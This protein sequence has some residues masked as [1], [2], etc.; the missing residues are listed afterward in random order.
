M[1]A[2]GNTLVVNPHPSGKRVAVEGVRRFNKAI[3]DDLGIDNLICVIA[4][5]TLE[6]ADTIFHHRD[7]AIDLCDRWASRRSCGAQQ[8]QKGCGCRSG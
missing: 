8:R 4:E 2:G 6:T 7:V 5:P 1:I 3:Y